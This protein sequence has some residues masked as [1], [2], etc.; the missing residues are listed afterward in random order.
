[1]K[2]K[3]IQ[4]LKTKPLPELRK[5]FKEWRERLRVLKF[6]LAA[7]KVKNVEELRRL[8]KDIARALTFIRAAENNKEE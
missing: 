7:G 1:M 6:D 8:R 5:L 2:K 3:E 4:E